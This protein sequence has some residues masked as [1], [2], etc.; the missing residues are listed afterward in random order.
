MSKRLTLA[1]WSIIALSSLRLLQEAKREGVQIT[2]NN[3]DDEI[4]A[5]EMRVAEINSRIFDGM[6]EE[7]DAE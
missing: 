2:L 3:L 6:E 5:A 7:S 4:E 1:D